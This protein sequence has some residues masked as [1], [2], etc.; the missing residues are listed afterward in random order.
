[1]YAL[2]P[3]SSVA[4]LSAYESQVKSNYLP[5]SVRGNYVVGIV[6]SLVSPFNPP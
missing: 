5:H 6:R 3:F 1:M 4:R 2:V